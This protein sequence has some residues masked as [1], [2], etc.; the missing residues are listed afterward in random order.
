MAQF[1]PV[2]NNN[3]NTNDIGLWGRK[4][5][6]IPNAST[7]PASGVA[8]KSALGGVSKLIRCVGSTGVLVFVDMDG[9]I[10]AATLFQGEY[11]PVQASRILPSGT[12]WEGQ[13]RVTTVTELDIYGSKN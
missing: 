2:S 7:V 8:I 3:S 10:N 1:P 11:C 9:E 13:A 12:T 4:V 5:Q 6:N